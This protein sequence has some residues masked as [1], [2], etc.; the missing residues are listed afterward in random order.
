[1]NRIQSTIDELELVGKI[2]D[3][4]ELQYQNMLLVHALIDLLEEK[5]I[6]AR[7]DLMEA[8]KRLDCLTHDANHPT[9]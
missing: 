8:A 2:A 9:K 7:E 3:I 4:K 6:I 5:K 1:M